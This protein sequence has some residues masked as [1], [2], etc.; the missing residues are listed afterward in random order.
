MTDKN[1]S[2]PIELPRRTLFKKAAGLSI[3]GVAGVIGVSVPGI[4]YAAA[5]TKEQRDSM[6]PDQV[7]ESL[8]QGNQRFRSGKPKHHDYL[9]QKVSSQDGQFPSAVILSCIDSRAP[10]EI[11]LDT[12]IGEAFNGRVAGNIANEDLLGSLEFACAAAGAKVVLVI[13][14]T[15]CGAVKGAI[16]NVELGNLTGLLE[17]IK[18]AVDATKF[19]GERKSSNDAFVDAVAKTNVQMTVDNIRSKSEILNTLEKEGKIKIVGSMYNLNDGEV[20]FF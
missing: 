1:V 9:A 7:V 17:K 20:V 19:D 12:G 16:D 2:D 14:H 18:P 13:G 5:L 4:S 6:T 15:G 11:L 3:L 8:K 10:A